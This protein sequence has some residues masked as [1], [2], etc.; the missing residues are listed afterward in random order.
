[1][2]IIIRT[3]ITALLALTVVGAV[4]QPNRANRPHRGHYE[5]YRYH[6]CI[7]SDLNLSEKQEAKVD[8]LFEKLAKER[9]EPLRY[10]TKRGERPTQEQIDARNKEMDKLHADL[11]KGMKKILDKEQ[12]AKWQENRT[13]HRERMENQ[14]GN[15]PNDG[16][17]GHRGRGNRG[18]GYHSRGNGRG[19]G[20]GNR[21]AA[22][23]NCGYVAGA[24]AEA[25]AK[26]ETK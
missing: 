20:D 18:E 23:P 6:Y 9:P 16:Y 8:E 1:M 7:T 2:R 26:S 4:A 3:A 13:T 24:K 5:G 10:Q 11:E 15:R 19:Y 17:R 12:F 22:C 14:R 25:E 21:A